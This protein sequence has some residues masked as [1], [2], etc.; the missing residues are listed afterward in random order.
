MSPS[1]LE[2]RHCSL[3]PFP[4]S[5]LVLL[6]GPLALSLLS[7]SLLMVHLLSFSPENAPNVSAR[8]SFVVVVVV[9]VVDG[10]W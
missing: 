7:F 5:P 2:S 9:V 3:I 10:S 6:P 4:I 1:C 8:Y